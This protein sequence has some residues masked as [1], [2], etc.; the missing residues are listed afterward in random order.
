MKPL[1]EEHIP[2]IVEAV[3]ARV[4]AL[5]CETPTATSDIMTR[6]EAKLYVKRHS[7]AAFCR[8]CQDWRVKPYR[9]GRYSRTQLDVALSFEA[10]RRG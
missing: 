7:N 6:A 5:L 8:W 3:A 1:T 10:R 4:V 2:V 9:R